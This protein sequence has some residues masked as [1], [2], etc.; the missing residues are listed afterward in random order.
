MHTNYDQDL[1]QNL[2]GTRKHHYH[3]GYYYDEIV[4]L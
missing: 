2:G 1:D 4:A 3:H